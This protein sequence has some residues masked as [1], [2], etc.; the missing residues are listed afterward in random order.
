[1]KMRITKI[2]DK[3]AQ[4]GSWTEYRG[5]S[6]KIARAGN[7][8]FAKSFLR[9]SRPYRK[10]IQANTVDDQIAEKILCEAIA[11]GILVDWKGFVID[12]TE[13]EYT[14]ENATALM[15]DDP[16]CREFVQEFSRDLNNYLTQDK[17]KV[18]EK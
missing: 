16:D 3:A 6:L 8:R 17:D 12:D 11:E 18:I 14:V 9:G 13:I 10:D 1:M 5:V 4:D 15:R 2:D 7:D